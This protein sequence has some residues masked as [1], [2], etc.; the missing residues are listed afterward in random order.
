M[1]AMTSQNTDFHPVPLMMLYGD[2]YD[3]VD[4]EIQTILTWYLGSPRGRKNEAVQCLNSLRLRRGQHE[5]GSPE[6]ERA[7]FRR[8]W[9]TFLILVK[10][11]K[12]SNGAVRDI[13]LL[14]YELSSMPPTFQRTTNPWSNLPGLREAIDSLW[15]EP[16]NDEDT[17]IPFTE[18][19][20]LNA[21]AALLYGMDLLGCCGLGIKA[22]CRAYETIH[23]PFETL[24][25]CRV[26]AAAQW[27][28]FAP[29]KML[30]VMHI[31]P[32]SGDQHNYRSSIFTGRKVFSLERWIFWKGGFERDSVS[33][34]D[35]A[36]IA[37]TLMDRADGGMPTSQRRRH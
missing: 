2:D 11:I 10:Q 28:H 17:Y 14:I 13:A 6:S 29:A 22:L 15:H 12:R 36:G 20:N 3:E 26:K 21:F 25:D 37:F 33:Q 9:K 1:Q 18:W 23:P 24:Q 30:V 31:E 35:D 16:T 27:M 5:R 32:R 19:V 4:R 7:F 8:F 34:D